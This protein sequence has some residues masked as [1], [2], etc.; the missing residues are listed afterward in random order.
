MFVILSPLCIQKMCAHCAMDCGYSIF[1]Q[2]IIV[3]NLLATYLY[4]LLI[5]FQKMN[6]YLVFTGD[7][8]TCRPCTFPTFG[9]SCGLW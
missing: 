2:V 1:S 6:V 7:G 3:I 8:E 9:D 5:P 4:L